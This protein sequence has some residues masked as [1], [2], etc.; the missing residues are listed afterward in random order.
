VSEENVEIVR[1]VYEAWQR[2]GVDVVP[3]LMDPEVEWLNPVYALEPGSRRGYE[4]FAAAAAAFRSV[5][6]VDR[7][8]VGEVY[9]AGDRIVVTGWML[10]RSAG[11]QVP[12]DA[13]RGYVFDLR[14]GKIIRFAWFSDPAEA[15]REVGVGE[16]GSRGAF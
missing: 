14:D 5:Y 1:R 16:Q 6:R 12:V 8:S 4:E 9:D 11:N 13:E 10:A 2:D 7:F 3:E 15:L